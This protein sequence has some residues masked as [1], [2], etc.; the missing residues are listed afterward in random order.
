MKR[1]IC[2]VAI[3]LLALCV[4][5]VFSQDYINQPEGVTYDSA[6]NRYLVSNWADGAIIEIDSTGTQSV[7][8]A[9]LGNCANSYI[10]DTL[11]WVCC[12]N[13]NLVALNLT[14]GVPLMSLPLSS[15]GLHDVCADTSGYLY[16]TN[17]NLN[18][19][20]RVDLS[21][22]SHETFIFSGLSKPSG[23]IFDEKQNRLL[24]CSFGGN[25]DIQA[26][27]L[28]TQLLN[29]LVT[30]PFTNL[31]DLA[32]DNR[33][34][35]Y[36]S[37]WAVDAVWRYDSL[38]ANPPVL[39]GTGTTSMTDICYNPV[40]NELAVTHYT[41]DAISYIPLDDS[42][43]DAV[44]DARDNCPS[45]PNP[46][47]EDADS[48][49]IGDACDNCP[50]TANF[51]QV[52]SDSDPLGDACDNCPELDNPDQIDI[53]S[54]DV[55]DLCEGCCGFWAGG[56]TGNV[57]GSTD[58]KRTLSDV[59]VLIDHVYISQ[60]PLDCPYAGNTNGSLDHKITLS[61]ITALIDHVYVSQE[62]TALCL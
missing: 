44:P 24:I 39:M 1:V 2:L 25:D 54:N 56:Y 52:N 46:G 5:P 57:N 48:D 45:T 60:E 26:F 14:T 22:F 27:D 7:F 19:V 51:G 13:R 6:N 12:S 43:D 55:G 23:I 35:Y 21:D 9:G 40:A 20:Y 18:V 32:R 49:T 62:P 61:D 11:F 30:A 53:N 42:D 3:V 17:W 10:Q 28:G 47:Q 58:G 50:G 36:V 4:S 38:F 34:Y 33:G 8:R 37:T 29:S 31:D 16:A 15:Y 41:T 59:T